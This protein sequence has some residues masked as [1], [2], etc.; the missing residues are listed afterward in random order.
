MTDLFTE[1]G[2]IVGGHFRDGYRSVQCNTE[3]ICVQR[4]RHH[5]EG[6]PITVEQRTRLRP[7]Q[8][9]HYVLAM[10]DLPICR[11]RLKDILF[12]ESGFTNE[13]GKDPGDL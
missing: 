6:T 11:L 2:F 7:F 5:D 10:V 8:T 3:S 13:A 4:E 9:T 1:P 12:S